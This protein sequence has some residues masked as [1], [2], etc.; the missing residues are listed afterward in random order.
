MGKKDKKK[1]KSGDGEKK[2]ALQLKKEAKADKSARK[3]LNK[4]AKE[5]GAEQPFDDLLASYQKRDVE[6]ATP[7]LESLGH[8]VFPTP[9]RA[10]VS[11][12]ACPNPGGSGSGSVLYLFGGEY[13]DGAEN[14][15]FDDLYRWDPD[16]TEDND[17]GTAQNDNDSKND[18]ILGDEND[19]NAKKQI[20]T[21]SSV[22]AGEWKQIWTPTPRPPARCSHTGVYFNGG[23]YVFGGELATADEY[24]HYKDLWRLDLKSH[25]WKEIVAKDGPTSRSGHR[26]IVWRHYMVVFGGFYEALRET[27]W[28]NDLYLFDFQTEKWTPLAFSKLSTQPPPRS[29]CNFSLCPGTDLAI[30]SGGYS[31]LKHAPGTMAADGMPRKDEGKIHSDTWC[32]HLKPFLNGGKLPTW[33][34]LPRRGEYPSPRSGTGCTV[35]KNKLL[36]YGGVVDQESEHHQVVSVFYDDLFAFDMERRRWFRLGLKQNSAGGRR[37]KKKDTS[38]EANNA[39]NDDDDD[40]DNDDV[41][42]DDDEEENVPEGEARSSGWDLDM[43]RS[44]MFAFI[45]GDGNIVYEKIE[46]DENDDEEEKEEVKE[47]EEEEKDEEKEE[48]EEKDDLK[49]D[50]TVKQKELDSQVAEEKNSKVLTS[51]PNS[52][53][54]AVNA[55]TKEPEAVERT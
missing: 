2:A 40:N 46:P 26:A 23:L 36:V 16:A 11:L 13:Y 15:V 27:K 43:L 3:R 51:L 34:R 52:S 18:M 21:Q 31:K 33:D 45:D 25:Q 5:E 35:H 54:L 38:Q 39:N 53:V 10:N 42:V 9:P 32:L 55:T 24:H 22:A 12:T 28:H 41:E 14:I 44:N 48:E 1:S 6:V 7:V 8:N 17:D 30:L 29:G 20:D 19:S 50:P 49:S 47:E 4:L 37:R